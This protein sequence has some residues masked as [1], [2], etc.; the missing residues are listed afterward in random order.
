MY[1]MIS[2]SPLRVNTSMSIS[3]VDEFGTPGGKSAS[4]S[5]NSEKKHSWTGK[6]IYNVFLH[7]TRQRVTYI[8]VEYAVA[9]DLAALK[10]VMEIFIRNIKRSLPIFNL[11]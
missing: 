6:D 2:T 7:L 9:K 5:G 3:L 8:S 10:E 1:D 4:P 11:H